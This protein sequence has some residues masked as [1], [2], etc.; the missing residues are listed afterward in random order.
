MEKKAAKQLRAAQLNWIDEIQHRSG[1]NFSQMTEACNLYAKNT[2]QRSV[3]KDT[4]RHFFYNYKD[5][6]KAENR[7][8]SDRVIFM[9]YKAYGLEPSFAPDLLYKIDNDKSDIGEY[10]KLCKQYITDVSMTQG[11]YRTDV[12]KGAGISEVDLSRLFNDKLPKG[13]PIKK[14]EAI[15]EKYKVN[16]PPRLRQF[17]EQTKESKT[18]VPLVGYVSLK[19]GDQ[20]WLLGGDDKRHLPLI[21]GMN[22]RHARAIELRGPTINALVKDGVILYFHDTSLG[23]VDSCIDNTCLVEME[24]GEMFIKLVERSNRAGVYRLHSLV[25]GKITESKL[26]RACKIEHI[27]Q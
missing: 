11:I 22:P 1:D 20:V 6:S 24:S 5:A 27:R 16:F 23:V 15:R 3:G 9:L 8:L 4:L 12:A 25:D 19:S 14:L 18:E 13:L 21:D 7:V 10:A 2:G 17:L 26:K